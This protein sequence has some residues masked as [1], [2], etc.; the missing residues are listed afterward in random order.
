M[1]NVCSEF[2]PQELRFEQLVRL[3]F[4]I[5]VEPSFVDLTQHIQWHFRRTIV[6]FEGLLGHDGLS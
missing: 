4:A 3:P 2:K 6:G 1:S 5:K